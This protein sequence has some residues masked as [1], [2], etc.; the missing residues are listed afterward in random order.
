[1]IDLPQDFKDLL[2]VFAHH[3][4]RYLII[5]G[6]AVA[7]HGK[8]R[9]TKDIDLWIGAH[10]DN[11]QRVFDALKEF[12]VSQ[13]VLDTFQT[14]QV[15]EILYMGLPPVRFEI[16]KQI[17]GP[18][19]EEAW[20]RRVLTQWNEIEVSIMGLEDLIVAKRAVARPQD[21]IDLATLEKKKATLKSKKKL[22]TE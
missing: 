10:P 2:Q 13:R 20:E 19:F 3:R 15:D 17:P 6:Y 4:V 12:G 8:P 11:A 22:K 14:L 18:N 21:C 1:M 7:F 16:F 5:G 9:F